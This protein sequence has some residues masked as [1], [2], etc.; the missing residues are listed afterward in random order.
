MD[1][2]DLAKIACV[3]AALGAVALL[4]G[5]GR[6]AIVGGLTLV[7]LAGAGLIGSASDI[8]RVDALASAPG[9]AAAVLGLL[10]LW[11]AA[12]AFVRWP[13]TVPLAVLVCAPLRPPITLGDGDGFP[14]GI[15]DDGELGRLLPL[16]FVLAAAGLALAWRV[17]GASR[18]S[19]LP[20]RALPRGLALPAAAFVG[21]LCVSLLWADPI[22]PGVD[23]L[24]FFALPF[25]V[26]VAVVARAPFPDWAPRALGIAA[27]ALAAAFA[28]I[29]LFQ[30]ATRELFFFAPNLQASNANSGYFRVTSLFGDPSLYGRHLVLGIAVLL[31]LMALLRIELRLAIATLAL[32]W[33]GLFFSYSQS[34]MIALVVVTLAVAAFTGTRRVRVTVVATF[35][36][37]LVV[38]VGYVASIPLRGESL[39]T[40]TADRSQRVEDSVRVIEDNPVVGV[41]VGAQPD[42]SRRLADQDR[43]TA[44]FVSH[45]A[46][47]T[48]AAELGAVGL[49]LLAWLLY[50]ATRM[51]LAVRRL[52]AGMGLALLAVLLGLF[53]Q[54][55]FYP[56]FLDD[57][58]TW[59]VL[60]LGAGYVTW[61]RAAGD[62][63]ACADAAAT[64]A[65][66]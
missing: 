19:T 33:A 13:A 12:A 4:A 27:L 1:N 38:G 59:M 43:A 55:L 31:S 62:G 48:V 57:P 6:M 50:G 45:T 61:P 14:I 28:A 60:A 64:G 24:V 54:A 35:L 15:A 36:A 52:D 58:L 2:P 7:G 29:G 40:E 34:S 21:F 42:A 32:L 47:L 10:A 3:V 65:T 20:A 23:T 39:R 53:T 41:G 26:L 63:R 37:V 8:G 17:L 46:P 9:A 25:T 66:A 22:R 51:L 18:D 11:A 49:A 44:T 56:G 16:Y 30:E 5:R